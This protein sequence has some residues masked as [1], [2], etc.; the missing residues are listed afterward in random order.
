[1]KRKPNIVVIMADQLAPRFCGCYGHPI[2]KT[3]N[4]DRLS[5]RGMRFDG[6]Y[7]NS[8]ICAPAR[9]S[10]MTGQ[11]I[12]RIAAYDNV[13]EFSAKIPTFA[14]YLRL[15]GYHTCLSGDMHFI[16]PDQ[17][18]GFEDR[19]T[20]GICT[21]E[22]GWAPDWEL[23]DEKVDELYTNINAVKESGV[24]YS[25]FQLD[26]DE[27]V[28]FT[29]N[30]WLFNIARSRMK[31]NDAPFALVASFIHP[32][33]PYI[34]RPEWWNLY[35]DDEIELPQFVLT[36]E[37]QDPYSRRIMLG[38]GADKIK[39]TTEEIIRARRGYL[40]NVSY[41]D[42]K[43]GQI[44]QT[45]TEIDE[46]DNTIIIVTSDHGDMLGDRGLWFKMNFFEPSVRVP[47]IFAGPGIANGIAT[48][49]CSLLDLL[50]TFID[51]AGGDNTILGEP[52]DG[53]SLLPLAAGKIDSEDIAIGEYC[54]ELTS[55]PM[56]MIRRKQYK[57]I[58][59]ES[60]PPLLFDVVSDALE[61][62]NLA[63]NQEYKELLK[64]FDNEV[65]TS[66]DFEKLREDIV[67]T[68]KSRKL[69][70]NSMQKGVKESW[71]YT[72]PYYADKKYVRGTMNWPNAT[73]EYR[74]PPVSAT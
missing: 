54:A 32:H 19:L 10:F 56:I 63:K 23:P 20:T 67:K 71:D 68:Q 48:N 21:S 30:R 41:F 28:G 18:H 43:V 33:D 13:S 53:R 40:A 45:L 34:A 26:Y 58:H 60:Y 51:I 17:K 14:H 55:Y 36:A 22:F 59:C 52:I 57:Y 39:L 66:W 62:D 12:S 47:L 72:P 46:I 7:T 24:A 37:E 3:P 1:M 70:F 38:I 8:P 64:S 73:K 27:E 35:T 69:L 6:A 74:Y 50:P 25:T 61:K 15:L 29:T 44:L 9:F 31:G 65:Q 4:I 2:A 49:T 16:G 42:H 5:R 11:L